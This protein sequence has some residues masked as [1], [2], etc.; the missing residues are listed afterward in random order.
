MNA[1]LRRCLDDLESRIDPDI[2]RDNR[3]AWKDFALG[4]ADPPVFF[5]PERPPNPPAVTWP[6]VHINDAQQDTEAMILDQFRMVSDTLAAGSGAR[7]NVRC[8][9]GTGILPSLFGCELFVMPRRT[10]TL[11]TVR[12]LEDQNRLR[13]LLEADPPD[14]EAGLGG[15]VFRCAEAFG[16]VFQQ[17]PAIGEAV[18]L[19][20]PD[21]QGPIDAVELLW[22]SGMFLGIYDAPD[23]LDGLLE[24][25]TRTHRLFLRRWYDRVGRPASAIAHW[26]MTHAGGL[27]LRNDSLMNLSPELYVE[28]IRPYDQELLDAFDGGA[29]HYCGRGEHF[30]GPV[31]ELSGLCAV[32]ASQPHLNDMDVVFEHTVEKGIALIGLDPEIARWAL[33]QGRDLH[34]RVQVTEAFRLAGR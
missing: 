3:Q 21:L 6:D 7:L 17:Y 27:M 12:P 9:Y 14:L 23:L 33:Q 10:N 34:G 5:P 19:Y 29:V 13:E 18:E 16:E 4:R 11:P 2:E 32:H 20:H 24:L 28:R 22:G 1:T 30:I 15:R 8:N 25:V 31:S 26:G